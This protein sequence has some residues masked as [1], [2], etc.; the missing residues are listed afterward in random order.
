MGFL[1][2]G[3]RA[4]DCKKWKTC[5]KCK[6][7]HPTPLHYHVFNK[8]AQPTISHLSNSGKLSKS[9][10]IVPVCV[11][12]KDNPFCEKLTYALLDTQSDSTKVIKMKWILV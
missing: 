7:K 10:M 8:G 1:I 4:A 6:G 2:P 3:H 11:S 5:G 12:H 9:S